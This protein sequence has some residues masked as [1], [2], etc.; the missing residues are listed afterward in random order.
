MPLKSS[1]HPSPLYQDIGVTLS[2]KSHCGA[3]LLSPGAEGGVGKA[4]PRGPAA[5]E[6]PVCFAVGSDFS[7]P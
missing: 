5:L 3:G 1:P 7:L 2:R 4:E 6:S